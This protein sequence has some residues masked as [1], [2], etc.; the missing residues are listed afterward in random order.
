MESGEPVPL[1]S[2]HFTVRAMD[3]LNAV[4]EVVLQVLARYFNHTSESEEQLP[5]WRMSLSS[6]WRRAFLH[7]ASS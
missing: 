4:Y 6:S 3:L 1:I 5:R 2:W 7:W